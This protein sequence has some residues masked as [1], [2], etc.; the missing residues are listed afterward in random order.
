MEFK[1][2][3]LNI[4]DL[5]V[6]QGVVTGYA[7]TFGVVDDGG[8]R[9]RK[10]AY[11]RTIKTWG[12]EGKRRIKAL[13]Q[14]DPAWLVGRPTI[15]REDDVGL[16]HETQFSKT[17]LANDVLT[18]IHDGVITEQSIGYDTIRKADKDG[19]REL[20]EL[21][22]WEYSFV[23]WGMNENTP[24]VGTKSLADR[25]NRMEKAL[26]EATF[27][28]D[29]VPLVLERALKEWQAALKAAE[30]D[31]QDKDDPEAYRAALVELIEGKALD[32][33]MRKHVRITI[34]LLQSLLNG[35]DSPDGTPAGEDSIE[36]ASNSHEHVL[37]DLAAELKAQ[38]EERAYVAELRALAR[39]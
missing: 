23:T 22:L 37:A 31:N 21:R 26:R 3:P 10:G 24:I 13:Y 27:E 39:R 15:L 7:S 35:E 6:K 17:R 4:N 20:Q 28:T 16:Y 14:H 18:L 19:V 2:G 29:E 8:D 25:M 36:T 1:S 30:V 32:D 9:V 5:D 34:D 33:G 11:A 38:R 12:P